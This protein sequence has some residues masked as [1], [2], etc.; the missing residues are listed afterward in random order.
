MTLRPCMAILI[1]ALSLAAC[2][3]S[4]TDLAVGNLNT[5]EPPGPWTDP[6]EEVNVIALSDA[7]FDLK[8]RRVRVRAWECR[9]DLSFIC[10]ARFEGLEAYADPRGEFTYT[11][12][13]EWEHLYVA[14][15]FH[16]ATT[17]FAA[18]AGV[19][20]ADSLPT[21]SATWTGNMV[22][23][24]RPP[25]TPMD[26][27]GRVVRGGA[28]I[29]LPDLQDPAIDVV[30][31]PASLP[32][33]TWKTVPV[34][35]DGEFFDEWAV[36]ADAPWPGPPNRASYIRGEFYGP[37]AEEVGGVFERAGIIGAFGAKRQQ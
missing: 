32:A 30:L 15:V 22:G 19:S 6:T 8:D 11:V 18:T 33:M 23:V 36:T 3:G 13:G 9:E 1:V 26:V 37:N 27:P 28:E 4:G 29:A 20:Y 24:H 5:G 2:G 31:T 10:T 17:L 35:D 16:D 12:L 14:V 7:I 34:A 25:E 21:G